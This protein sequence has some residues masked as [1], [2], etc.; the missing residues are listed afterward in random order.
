MAMDRLRLSNALPLNGGRAGTFGMYGAAPQSSPVMSAPLSS[1]RSPRLSAPPLVLASPPAQ[2]PPVL[3]LASVGTGFHMTDLEAR[4]HAACSTTAAERDQEIH[5]YQ[6]FFAWLGW[7]PEPRSPCF[8][9]LHEFFPGSLPGS[10]VMARVK[11]ALEPHGMDGDNTLYGQSI[12]PDEINNEKGGLADQMREHWGEVFPLGGI[13]APPFVGKT[14]FKAFSAH[15][16]EDG[17]IVI[18]FG[19]HIGIS[20][21]GE[22]GKY[23]R[24]GQKNLS[25]A[26]GAL[27]A[28]YGSCKEGKCGPGHQDP[29]DLQQTWLR[30]NLAPAM[31]EIVA[32]QNPMA[33]L[34]IRSYDMVSKKLLSIVDNEFGNGK[35]VLLGGVQINTPEG[36]EDHFM[37]LMFEVRQKNRNPVDILTAFDAESMANVSWT[38]RRGEHDTP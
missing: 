15:A 7:S 31:G 20:D 30:D 27:I 10:A 24:K 13:G 16:P 4:K 11:A 12:C 6:M 36:M 37:P 38:F 9:T 2:I 35:L 29:M 33:A 14:G 32:A 21:C 22:V 18:L 34:A 3:P 5:P 17:H 8:R 1:P 25:T 23:L 26:C 19:P 28:A